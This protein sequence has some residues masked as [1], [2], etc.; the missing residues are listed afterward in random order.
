MFNFFLNIANNIKLVFVTYVISL[1]LA[2]ILFSF[3]ENKSFIDSFY[4]ASVT[5]LTIGYGDISPATTIGKFISVIFGHFW[6][7]FIIPSVVSNILANL[8]KNRNEFTHEEQ[9]EIK[10]MLKELIKI[11]S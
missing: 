3:V 2:T 7:F 9:E 10:Q 5:S 8:I 11:K 6:I 1:I 4:W